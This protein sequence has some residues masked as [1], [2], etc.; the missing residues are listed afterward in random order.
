MLQGI[1]YTVTPSLV[2][3]CR[4]DRNASWFL[5]DVE[6]HYDIYEL[7]FRVSLPGISQLLNYV[8]RNS[9]CTAG[10]PVS[11]LIW[12]LL[13]PFETD[14]FLTY[15]FRIIWDRAGLFRPFLTRD[16]VYVSEQRI[17][18]YLCSLELIVIV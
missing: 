16:I 11:C 18:L 4:S 1:L 5:A 14:F 6:H 9:L 12:G 7:S 2:G 3:T 10:I 8:A 17:H 13:D 15:I